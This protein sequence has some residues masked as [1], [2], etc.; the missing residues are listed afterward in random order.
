MTDAFDNPGHDSPALYY[1][2]TEDELYEAQ[3]TPEGK[4]RP[5][6]EE[7]CD[8]PSDPPAEF[9]YGYGLLDDVPDITYGSPPADDVA[10]DIEFVPS[11]ASIIARE[12]DRRDREQVC[13]FA[14]VSLGVG[15]ML[16]GTALT[17]IS[18]SMWSEAG[19]A[20]VGAAISVVL[21][22]LTWGVGEKKTPR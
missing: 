16:A 4:H 17:Y 7:K 20:F 9:R 21:G 1:G 3:F 6:P 13:V 2:L 14:G 18:M 19:I 8:L 22:C 5:L 10:D 11:P 12:Q 15:I